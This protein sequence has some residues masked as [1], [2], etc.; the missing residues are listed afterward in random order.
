MGMMRN[1]YTL[2]DTCISYRNNTIKSPQGAWSRNFKYPHF[3]TLH[4]IF[5]MLRDEGF[6]IENDEEVAKCIRRDYYTGRRGD[7]E[8]YASR[9][10]A[11]FEIEFFQNVV[12]NNPC[13]GRYDFDK[14]Q[15]M[16]YLIQ[17]QFK[18]YQNKIIRL[19]TSLEDV[20]DRTKVRPRFAEDKIKA[21]YMESWHHE[22]NDMNFSLSDLDGQTQEVYNGRDRNNLVLHNGDIKYFR[23]HKG[24]LCRGRIY[25]NI[26]N[27]WWV[28]VDRFTVQNVACFELFDLRPEDNRHRR[29]R[30]RIPEEYQKRREAIKNTK[31]KELVNELRRRGIKTA[32]GYR[33]RRIGGSDEQSITDSF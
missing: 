25:H 4:R 27:M 17:L 23:N 8:F 3:G 9:Y 2:Y 12:V 18:K 1:S 21:N 26:N 22:Q 31:T 16:P 29:V 14:F 33:Q 30:P 11:G 6:T 24:Y 19:L 7:L 28:I 20:E 5:N 32:G 15:K 13:G 10:P